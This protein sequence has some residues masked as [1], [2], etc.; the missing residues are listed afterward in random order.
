MAQLSL[1]IITNLMVGFFCFIS[2]IG[3]YLFITTNLMV[4][5]FGFL[6]SVWDFVIFKILSKLLIIIPVYVFI[7]RV[8]NQT[9]QRALKAICDELIK[10]NDY[11]IEFIYKMEAIQK[12]DEL[13]DKTISELMILKS[14]INAH[15]N[16][17]TDNLAAFPY[18]GPLNYIWFFCFKEYLK[19]EA[20]RVSSDLEMKYQDLI[21][22]ETILSL[23]IDFIVDRSI[24][25][26]IE[27]VKQLDQEVV[28]RM[29]NTGSRLQQHLEDNT[30]KM[31]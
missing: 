12:P 30:R 26:S 6:W 1:Y 29:I 14:K 19:D 16:Y 21:T 20:V 31:F 8:H 28:D 17:I 3:H 25:I 5:F 24:Q 9:Q 27:D 2:S 15:L 10:V 4:S 11:V 18:G 7:Q 23:E 22:F 13:D